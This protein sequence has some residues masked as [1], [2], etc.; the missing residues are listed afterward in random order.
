M[1]IIQNE[2]KV[3]NVARLFSK[4][5]FLQSKLYY[6]LYFIAM[7]KSLIESRPLWSSERALHKVWGKWDTVVDGKIIVPWAVDN[8]TSEAEEA[9]ISHD[10]VKD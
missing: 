3:N 2:K 7:R 6:S 4:N 5:I 8:T 9:K 1:K 10:L